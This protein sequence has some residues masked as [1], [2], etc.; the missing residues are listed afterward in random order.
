MTG[1]AVHV[2]VR[3]TVTLRDALGPRR[4][5]ALPHGATV[6]DL[7]DALAAADGAVAEALG[8][9]V[10]SVAGTTVDRS[11][12]LADGDEVALI[13]PVAGGSCSSRG[14]T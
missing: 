8:R 12:P 6:A 4:P 11:R 14:A 10:V 13:L 9:V 1:G 3:S 7:L 5:V 2:V